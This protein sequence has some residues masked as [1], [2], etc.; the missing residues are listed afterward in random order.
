MKIDITLK[1]TPKMIKDANGNEKKSF[2]GH[3]GTHFDVMNKVFPIEYTNRKAVFFDISK[4]RDKEIQIDDIDL[5]KVEKDM[6]VGFSSLWIEDK[7]Y[8]TKDYFTD[9]PYLSMELIKALVKK[10]ISIIGVDFPGVR[11]H[12]EHTPTDQYLADNNVFVVENL[13]NLKRL[14]CYKQIR[15]NTY[16]MSFS[17]MSGLPCRVVLDIIEENLK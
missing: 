17:D 1:V 6:F 9:H 5:S 2:S 12:Q 11:R 13:C 8:G 14:D 7:E 15:A 4:I 10:G 16:P 3:I